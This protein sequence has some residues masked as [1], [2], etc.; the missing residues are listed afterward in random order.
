M[1]TIILLLTFF[2]THHAVGQI[3]GNKNIKTVQV[4]SEGLEEVYI[5]LNVDIEIF[6]ESDKSFIEVTTDENI[7][8]H[9]GLEVN[10]GKLELDQKK[11]IESSGIFQ[12]K[13]YA[14]E[15]RKVYND[16]WVDLVLHLSGQERFELESTISEITLRGKVG[17]LSVFTED[18]EID[19]TMLEYENLITKRSGDGHIIV[20]ENASKTY[21]EVTTRDEMEKVKASPLFSEARFIDFRIR[22]NRDQSFSAYVKGPKQD[23]TYFSYGLNFNKN[24]V[25]NERWSVGTK[26]YKINRLGLKQELLTIKK[27]DEGQVVDIWD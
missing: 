22:N 4:K 8:P 14:P 15:L 21:D 17:E 23:G 12:I 2:M 1:R 11:W 9:I 13:I 6:T 24:Q 19:L 7:I 18:S 27:E 3:R 26:L 10:N 16:S 25:K 5:N 20:S